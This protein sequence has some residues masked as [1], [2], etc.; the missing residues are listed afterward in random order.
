MLEATTGIEPV[1]RALQAPALPLGHVAVFPRAQSPYVKKKPPPRRATA[2]HLRWSGR[3]DSNPRPQPWQGC[4]LPTEPLPHASWYLSKLSVRVKGKIQA[5]SFS[6]TSATGKKA[7]RLAF[8]RFGGRHSS[9]PTQPK[10]NPITCATAT[11]TASAQFTLRIA[12]C[13]PNTDGS[14]CPPRRVCR[15]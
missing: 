8:H 13:A 12:A 3:R 14:P 5:F 6:C 2:S 10:P 4:A 7:H 11:A 9:C 1:I 15:R